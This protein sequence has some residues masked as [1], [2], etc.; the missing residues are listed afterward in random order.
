MPKRRNKG[1]GSVYYKEDKKLWSCQIT[2][3]YDH[4]SGKQIRKTLYAKTKSDL[5]E[6][7]KEFERA[8]NLVEK[9]NITFDQNFYR[10][11]YS[12][13]KPELKEKSW[14]RY[15]GLYR[16][17]IADAPFSNKKIQE[18]TYTDIKIWYNSMDI[19]KSSLGFI[20][21]LIKSSL[22]LAVKD[23]IISENILEDVNIKYT[24][25]EQKYNVLSI[26]EQKILTEYLSSCTLKQEPLK[27]LFL[28]TLSTGLRLGEVLALEKTDIQNNAVSISKSVERVKVNG[29]YKQILTTPKTKSSIRKVPLPEKTADMIKSMPKSDSKLLFPDEKSGGFIF[30]NR[31]LKRILSLCDKLNI[32]RITFHG[33]RHTY[34]TRLF[35]L[36]VQIKTVQKLMGHSDIQ[37][38]MNIYTHVMPDVMDK[39]IESLNDIL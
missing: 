22:K 1:E 39:A 3:G 35:E 4:D 38:T 18:L 20:N 2:V 33:L 27:Y 16:N 17:Y 11:L 19:S 10:Y 23:K 5:I 6:K 9:N 7:K 31:P 8:N 15:E 28:F 14:E 37:T 21:M 36:N 30:R 25:D 34:A 29:N 24:P 26:D 13:K 32:T 12:I